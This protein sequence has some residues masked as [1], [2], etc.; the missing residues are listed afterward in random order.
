MTVCLILM[1]K[2]VFEKRKISGNSQPGI[3]IVQF[4]GIPGDLGSVLQL[5]VVTC[6]FFTMYCNNSMPINLSVV[7]DD[8][9]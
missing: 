1:L 2:N 3:R 4:S 8:V 7:N 6:G 9:R 5:F